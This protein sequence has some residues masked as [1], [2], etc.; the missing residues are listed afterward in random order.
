MLRGQLQKLGTDQGLAKSADFSLDAPTRLSV[1]PCRRYKRRY[2]TAH[3]HL[4]RRG[5]PLNVRA[6]TIILF[7]MCKDDLPANVIHNEAGLGSR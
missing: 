5:I 6:N 4:T 2:S 3:P 1:R 7:V